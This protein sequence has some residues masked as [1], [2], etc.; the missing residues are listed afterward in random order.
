MSYHWLSTPSLSTTATGF[1]AAVVLPVG[2]QPLQLAVHDGLAWDT[3]SLTVEIINAAEAVDRL[4]A[5][6]RSEV[7]RAQPLVAALNA[8]LASLDRSQPVP[9]I[10]QLL[11]FQNQ[12]RGQVSPLDQSLADSLIQAAQQ[13]ID[14]LTGG[15]TNPG[16]RLHGQ[17]TSMT[18]QASGHVR[19]Q[20]T[21]Q[22][23]ALHLIEA[24]TNMVDWELIG[25][26]VPREQG[27]FEFEESRTAKF[28]Q[29]FYRVRSL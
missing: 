11:A 23:G 9:A 12:V 29:R 3:N 26:A 24:S 1:I 2:T 10:N 13:I 20:F 8:A 6:L 22:S 7:T 15:A 21:G 14:A 16:G 25:A 27:Q 18:R 28:M 4:A 5:T 17:F 19:L